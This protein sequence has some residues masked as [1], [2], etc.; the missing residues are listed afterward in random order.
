MAYSFTEKK[1][2]RKNFG[3][4]PNVMDLPYLL[5]IQI[6][7]YK[8]F[9]QLGVSS[10]E[11]RDTGLHA[12]LDS[13]FPI[14]GYAGYAAL[15]YVDY[16]LGKPSFDVDECK[17]RGVTFSVPLRVRVRLVIYDRDSPNKAIMSPGPMV[18]DNVIFFK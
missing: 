12:A 16:I 9:T 17:L 11:R 13:I 6:D 18:E 7:S 10:D 5:A 15:E 14:V 8:N 3:K 2:I 1:R 4:L